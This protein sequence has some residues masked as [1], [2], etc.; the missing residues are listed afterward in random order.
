MK[1]IFKLMKV[2]VFISFAWFVVGAAKPYWNK[3]WLG[4]T[5]ENAAIYGTKNN[6]MATR[7]FLTQKMNEQGSD[8]TGEDFTIEKDINNSATISIT[9]SDKI[10]FFGVDL[11]SLHF[12]IE[13]TAS[14]VQSMF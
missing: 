6:I 7:R 2:V 11:I 12:T 8:F 4:Q 10:S 1:G 13:K 3:Y 14:E 5:I 9:Y